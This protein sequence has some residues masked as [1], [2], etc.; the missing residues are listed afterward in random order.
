MHNFNCSRTVADPGEAEGAAAPLYL[1]VIFGSGAFL[2]INVCRILTVWDTV[3]TSVACCYKH[4][5]CI[6]R[7]VTQNTLKYAISKAN[8]QKKILAQPLPHPFTPLWHSA[9]RCPRPFQKSWIRHCSR[10]P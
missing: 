7:I 1:R 8:F 4:D 10:S 9:T 5:I 2:C 6:C 3:S